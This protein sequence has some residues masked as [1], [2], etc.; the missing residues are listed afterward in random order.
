LPILETARRWHQLGDLRVWPFWLD[1]FAIGGFLIY[2]AWRTGRNI[3]A[4]R[5]ILAAAWGFACGLAYVS[6]FSEFAILGQPDPSG[7]DPTLVIVIKGVMF[8]IAI[9]ALVVTL[10]W[11]PAA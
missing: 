9:A 2:A 10:Q 1:D 11:Q 3:A 8:A 5:P 6:F 4:G 7:L